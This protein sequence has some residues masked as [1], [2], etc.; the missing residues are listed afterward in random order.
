MS[1]CHCKHHNTENVGG[2]VGSVNIQ[3]TNMGRSTEHYVSGV[4]VTAP[5][6]ECQCVPG[7]CDW[8]PYTLSA[9]LCVCVCVCACESVL[10]NRYRDLFSMAGQI[11]MMA[12]QNQFCQDTMAGYF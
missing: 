9:I 3:C 5:S 4:I 7:L 8:C 6:A 1:N 2:G 11:F 12:G 10:L